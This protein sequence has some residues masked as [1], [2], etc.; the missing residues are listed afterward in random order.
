M[1]VNGKRG[2]CRFSF[3]RYTT[4]LT[5]N[6]WNMGDKNFVV[7]YILITFAPQNV[8]NIVPCSSLYGATGWFRSSAG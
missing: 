2:T 7:R 8:T 6:I 3:L 1:L 4:P 5:G